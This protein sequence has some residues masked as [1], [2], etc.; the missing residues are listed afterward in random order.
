M[1]SQI[2]ALSKILFFDVET[3]SQYSSLAELEKANPI[4]AKLWIK[5]AAKLR[6]LTI[7]GNEDKSD[8]DLY[9]DKAPLLTPFNKIIAIS[10]AVI[11]M[12]GETPEIGLV[13]L[14]SH[15]EKELL[16]K[17]TQMIESLEAKR[18]PLL[19]SGHNIAGFDIPLIFN[20]NLIH[21]LEIPKQFNTYDKKPWEIKIID[22]QVIYKNVSNNLISLDLLLATH[23][24]ETSK[25]DI[26]GPEVNGVYWST[27][28]IKRIGTYCGKDVI[29]VAK[30][31]LKFTGNLYKDV[32]VKIYDK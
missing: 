26:S 5:E 2:G 22:T 12:T 23:G 24:I 14:Y 32:S 31:V 20:K 6:K 30:L 21:G 29:A 15:D 4:M 19:L 16:Q 11:T 25:D 17:F 9:I 1:L 27:Q 3:A 8:E 7:F 10:F 28:D 13:N 18:S